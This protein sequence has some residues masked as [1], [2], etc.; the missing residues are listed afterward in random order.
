M[1]RFTRLLS[2]S[3][4]DSSAEGAARWLAARSTRRSFLAGV[5]R[6]A[7]IGTGTAAVAAVLTDQAQARVC[8]QSGVSPMCPTYDCVGP[9]VVFGY[10]WYASPGCCAN[11][12]L[13]KICDCCGVGY[14]N[15]QGYCPAGSAVYCVVESC[16]E[17][18][19]VQA[20]PLERYV[21]SNAREASIAALI[22]RSAGSAAVAVLVP[23]DDSLVVALAMPVAAELGAP[24]VACDRST[25]PSLLAEEL[26]R[27]GVRKFVVVGSFSAEVLSALEGLGSVE[28]V[29]TSTDQ[30]GISIETARWM[31]ERTG[32]FEAVCVGAGSAAIT[33]APVAGAY[34]ALR[35]RPLLISP[36]AVGAFLG[37]RSAGVALIGSEV[38]GANGRFAGSV[39]INSDDPQVVSLTVA[40]RVFRAT[41]ATMGITFAD[42]TQSFLAAPLAGGA[43]VVLV[44]QTSN[45]ALRDWLIENRKR[46]SGAVLAR[47]TSAPA[48]DSLVY[49]LQSA[50]NGYDAHLLSGNDGDGLERREVA[51]EG[52][53]DLGRERP[54]AA[55]GDPESGAQAALLPAVGGAATDQRRFHGAARRNPAGRTPADRHDRGDDPRPR[56][57]IPL[58]GQSN[59]PAP[60]SPMTNIVSTVTATTTSTIVRH[61]APNQPR[62]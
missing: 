32:F 62:P 48:D 46:F 52:R 33:I 26:K 25:I 14:K 41:S 42:T 27:V 61:S 11:G 24:L 39:A 12:G 6:V 8:G 17:D 3:G 55:A 22:D 54:G 21:V 60:N 43:C 5:A 56:G 49:A 19:R 1:G 44:P 23:G 16:L 28:R 29:S 7:M 34:A 20:V 53:Q 59:I 40:N 4:V 13:K 58:L 10:C 45:D 50:L 36:D 9:D 51:D 38:S 15:V 31:A 57:Q 35:R 30:A 18:P 37:E 47:A 2:S